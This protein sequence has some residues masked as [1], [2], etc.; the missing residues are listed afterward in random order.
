MWAP[1]EF[2]R[3]FHGT[4]VHQL[5]TNYRSRPKILAFADCIL[6]PAKQ[7]LPKQLRASK[8]DSSEPVRYW[9][10]GGSS[11]AC[12]STQQSRQTA[13]CLRRHAWV[14]QTGALW[15]MCRKARILGG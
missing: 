7:L 1:Q 2:Q 15:L 12:H 13:T 10:M 3:T 6:A 11:I 4:R 14:H 5:V 9:S 8:A